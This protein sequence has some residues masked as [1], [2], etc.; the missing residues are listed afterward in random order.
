MRRTLDTTVEI[1]SGASSQDENIT[2]PLASVQ[3][4][5]EVV[6]GPRSIT[7]AGSSQSGARREDLRKLHWGDPHLRWLTFERGDAIPNRTRGP[8]E[9]VDYCS[10]KT[11]VGETDAAAAAGSK[12]TITERKAHAVETSIADWV[13][14]DT[15]PR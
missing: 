11:S 14:H 10:F 15:R 5:I 8:T 6:T 3:Q 1:S 4:S 12:E 7:G 2:L 9:I 13:D